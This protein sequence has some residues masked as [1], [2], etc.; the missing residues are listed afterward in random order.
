MRVLT[1]CIMLTCAAASM[2]QAGEI[3]KWTDE[4]GNVHYTDKPVGNP[5]ERINITS[6]RTDNTQVQ[7]RVQSRLNRQ[8][9]KAEAEKEAAD[10]SQDGDV[11][12]AAERSQ[13][14][15]TYKD[16][17]SNFVRSRRLYREDDDGERS[18]LDENEMQAAREK[19]QGQVEKYCGPE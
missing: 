6:R 14:C 15:D 3:Y 1:F 12:S 2:S 5:P 17:L 16:R 18:Y 10:G 11:E 8:A 9:E 19:V 13:K 7:A 4:A